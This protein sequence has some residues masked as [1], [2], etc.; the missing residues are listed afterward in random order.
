MGLCISSHPK[1]SDQ[2]PATVKVV[3]AHG[4]LQEF[5]HPIRA[6]RVASLSPAAAGGCFVCSSESMSIGKLVPQLGDEEELQLGQL[7][8]LLPVCF[9][10]NPLSISDLCGLAVKA[11]AAWKIA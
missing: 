10:R 5:T 11:S 9:A 1:R 2:F 3:S 7:Y 8:F 6:G 4:K